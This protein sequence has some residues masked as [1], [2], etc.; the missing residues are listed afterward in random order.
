MPPQSKT[1][2]KRLTRIV[3]GT[4]ITTKGKPLFFLTYLLF[5]CKG[6]Y[7]VGIMRIE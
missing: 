7:L 5:L 6:N 4:V 3:S 1:D 2:V